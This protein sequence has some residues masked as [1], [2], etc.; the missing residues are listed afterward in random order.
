MINYEVIDSI[1]AGC[2]L[3]VVSQDGRSVKAT[4]V[5]KVVTHCDKEKDPDGYKSF[6]TRYI[7]GT[8]N[9]TVTFYPK[10][11]GKIIFTDARSAHKKRKEKKMKSE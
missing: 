11:F 4:E 6:V 3:Y 2:V 10:D 9:G 5:L 1:R 8:T 7:S